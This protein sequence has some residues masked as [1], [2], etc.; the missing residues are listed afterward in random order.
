MWIYLNDAMLSIV[1]HRT[2]PDDLLVRARVAGDLERAFPHLA[3]EA[4]ETPDADYRYRIIVP[5]GDVAQMLADAACNIDYDN[6]KASIPPADQARHGAYLAC[7]SAMRALQTAS[8][9][10]RR[11]DRRAG[12]ER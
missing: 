8:S 7:W 2:Q 12:Q 6:F 5:R 3:G 11:I 9:T 4:V 10:W 1:A